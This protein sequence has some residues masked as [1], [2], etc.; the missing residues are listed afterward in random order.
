MGPLISL[1]AAVIFDMDGVLID[2]ER[3]YLVSF[4]KAS[5]E[6]GH[7]LPVALYHRVCGSPWDHITNTIL[8]ECGANFPMAAFREAWLRH[9]AQATADGIALKPGVATLLDLLDEIGLPR[10]IA[11]SSRQA[12]VE[13]HLGAHGILHRFDHVVAREDYRDPKPSPHPYLT[14]AE[15]LGIAPAQCLAL[16]DS[17]HGVRSA[18]SAGA[19]TVMVPDVAPATDEMRSCCVAICNGLPEVAD[20]LQELRKP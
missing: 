4:L 8:A 13:R 9:L 3:H 20:L 7:G 10:A 6:G 11:T 5:E 15:R 17:Y 19:M 16:E 18:F 1:P 2:T 14:A 12:A